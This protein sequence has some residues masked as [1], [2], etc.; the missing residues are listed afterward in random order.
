M[1]CNCNITVNRRNQFDPTRTTTL[2]NAFSREMTKRF[3]ELR[4]V[5]RTSVVDNDCFG[6][7]TGVTI[8]NILTNQMNPTSRNQF[9]FE[10]DGKKV[11]EFMRWL[12]TQINNGV[13]QTQTINQIGRASEEAWTNLYIRDSYRRGVN[14]ARQELRKAG[15]DVPII[16]GSELD[17]YLIQPFHI[18]R[19]GLLYTRTFNDLV[20]VTDNMKGQISR[21]LAR[22]I[23]EGD[24]PRDIARRLN[25][26]IKRSGGD[27][28][29]TD[30]IGRFIPAERRAEL[31][32]R[33]EIIRAHHSATIQEYRNF[34]AEGVR[35]RAEFRTAGDDRVCNECASL[36][37]STYSLDAAEGIIPVHPL[38]RCIMLPFRPRVDQRQRWNDIAAVKSGRLPKLKNVK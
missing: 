7:I 23:A 34:G 1:S 20:N 14:R 35:L 5:I 25:R 21:V 10:R 32:A 22:G 13:L 17:N 4:G 11:E 31:I 28:G 27:L 37:G 16:Q 2:R 12:Q 30:T 36:Q 19:V 24:N 9:A 6:L 33:T 8:P 26:V 38:C 29:V 18:D 3:R 15:F